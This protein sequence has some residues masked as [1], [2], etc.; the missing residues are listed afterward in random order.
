MIKKIFFSLL[1]SFTIAIIISLIGYNLY[2]PLKKDPIYQVEILIEP[3]PL[4]ITF[5][6]DTSS[7]SK[8]KYMN[9]SSNSYEVLKF[10]EK[11]VKSLHKY[12]TIGAC[13]LKKINGRVPYSLT[14]SNQYYELI[15]L[16]LLGN[17]E[18]LKKCQQDI[19]NRIKN[20]FDK[21]KMIMMSEYNEISF[22]ETQYKIEKNSK[23]AIISMRLFDQS[24]QS[25]NSNQAMLQEIYDN[26]VKSY[27][28]YYK[29]INGYTKK[30]NTRLSFVIETSFEI[31]LYEDNPILLK[32]FFNSIS[33][34]FKLYFNYFDIFN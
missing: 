23:D 1:K 2:S 17:E 22:Y 19:N 20:L 11:Y 5:G 24:G 30:N 4:L 10:L 12:Q 18:S 28:D 8:L 26:L 9:D 32:E 31:N 14:K 7:F 15:N 16:K 33:D 25:G 21:K 13:S 3:N 34:F 27:S 29:V 6:K